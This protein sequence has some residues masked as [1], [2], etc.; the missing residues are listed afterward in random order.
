[1]VV[2]TLA[3]VQVAVEPPSAWSL[4]FDGFDPAC[5]GI[6]E[7]LC[8]LGNGYFATR[9]AA[10][11][12]V[13]DDVHYPGTYLAGGYNRLRTEI[14]GRVVENEDVVNFPN[15]LALGFRIA[16]ADWF[17]VRTVTLLSYR[18]ELD[19]QR[20]MLF[21]AIRFEDAQGRR[22]TLKERR[23]VSISDMHLGAL[24]LALTAEN[25]SAHV[26]VRSAIDGRVVNRGAQIA[27]Q[28]PTGARGEVVGEDGWPLVRTCS[29][30]SCRAR[31][32]RAFVDGQL[33]E[34]PRRV[35]THRDT[36]GRNWG[37]TSS[38][39]RRCCWRSSPRAK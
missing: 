4:V 10:A 11:G 12:A 25:W 14:A 13:A 35:S 23:L 8:T 37:S 32:T 15:W 29:R 26:T 9:A 3:Q 5:E 33:R 38:T 19:L 30:I 18:Q 1:M 21:R 27:L 7:A 34:G 2:T 17:D 22:A 28:Q 16:D 6:R 31:R 39:A 36:S 24:E 20:G